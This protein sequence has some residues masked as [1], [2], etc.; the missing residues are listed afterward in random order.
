MTPIDTYNAQANYDELYKGVGNNKNLGV[1]D[2]C[3]L[4][5]GNGESHMT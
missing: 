2:S 5:F 4:L 1:T 3:L